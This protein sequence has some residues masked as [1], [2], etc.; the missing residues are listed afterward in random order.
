MN[1][2]V[3]DNIAAEDNTAVE[4]SIVAGDI[5]LRIRRIRRILLVCRNLKNAI[6]AY[7]VSGK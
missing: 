7:Q 5:H 3:G 4:G 1:H 2:S 6:T